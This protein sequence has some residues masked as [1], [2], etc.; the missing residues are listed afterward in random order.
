VAALLDAPAHCFHGICRGLLPGGDASSEQPAHS[1]PRYVRARNGGR[2]GVYQVLEKRKDHH[3]RTVKRYRRVRDGLEVHFEEGSDEWTASRAPGPRS[4]T[5]YRK[6][7]HASA[8]TPHSC[9]PIR[10]DRRESANAQ[11][12]DVVVASR[13]DI[14]VGNPRR[15]KVTTDDRRERSTHHKTHSQSS[16]YVNRRELQSTTHQRTVMIVEDQEEND[17]TSESYPDDTSYPHDVHST[18]PSSY[19]PIRQPRLTSPFQQP[20]MTTRHSQA[21]VSGRNAQIPSE[22]SRSHSEHAGDPEHMIG[23]DDGLRGR[24]R[25][26]Q[27]GRTTQGAQHAM[28]SGLE[29][30]SINGDQYE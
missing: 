9:I 1:K 22:L 27:R 26:R 5:P 16:R 14:D 6:P 3:R 25:S 11:R 20:Q 18:P 29:Q 30:H 4:G 23:S 10:I 21:M 17:A 24:Q 2:E 19:S 12:G 7:R 15:P 8:D 13:S 28:F